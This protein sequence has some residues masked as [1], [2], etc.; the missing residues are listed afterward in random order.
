MLRHI[1]ILIGIFIMT[2]LFASAYLDPGTGSYI[3]QILIAGILGGLY[4]LKAYGRK[5]NMAVRSCFSKRS[6]SEDPQ[7]KTDGNT[8]PPVTQ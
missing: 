4:A 7:H 8:Q 2:P 6:R 1:G 3:F 5:I